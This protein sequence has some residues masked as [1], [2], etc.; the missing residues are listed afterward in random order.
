MKSITESLRRNKIKLLITSC[1]YL[2]F[3]AHATGLSILGPSLL[4]LQAKTQSELS[5]VT[6][7][8]VG[9]AAGVG[10]GSM[11]NIF[12]AK[13]FRRDTLL[14]F[15]FTLAAI[16]EVAC[17]FNTNVWLMIA[18]LVIN[19]ICFGFNE[20][21]SVKYLID[22]WQKD[23][24]QYLQGFYLVFGLGALLTPLYT[25]PFLVS[26]HEEGEDVPEDILL[27]APE[28]VKIHWPFIFNGILMAFVAVFALFIRTINIRQSKE[29]DKKSN[30]ES[31]DADKSIETEE[32]S[33]KSLIIKYNIYAASMFIVFVY[34][35]I[36][37]AL[38]SYLTP[39]AVGCD[40]HLSKKTAALM[41]SAYWA[42]FTFGRI[43]ILP[44]LNYIGVFYCLIL[45]LAL[46]LLSNVFLFPF[47]GT[48]EWALWSGIIIN[49]LGLSPIW[50][51]FFAFID[52]KIPCTSTF[53]SLIVLAAC[54]GECVVPIIVS[55]FINDDPRMFLW[56]ILGAS[57]CMVG[58]FFILLILLYAYTRST[59]K[60]T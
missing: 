21:I 4:D 54:L 10:V 9:R 12:A 11:L 34:C 37:I 32:V 33:I 14:V 53:T 19:G 13:Y 49:G 60:S 40:M 3:F 38:G 47:G 27:P 17:P 29:Q 16:T 24:A 26:P 20:S 44:I 46:V 51:S 31:V 56:I 15:A 59:T 8:I 48:L 30:D 50:A 39:F 55:A 42:S 1:I 25:R 45:S 18:T 57:L 22:I 6:Y 36:E 41:S 2:A 52:S 5:Q 58:T 23:C 35:G 43:L 7:T 28:D